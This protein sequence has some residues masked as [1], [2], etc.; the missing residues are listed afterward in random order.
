MTFLDLTLKVEAT[1]AK[2]QTAKKTRMKRQPTDLENIFANCV[3]DKKL[4]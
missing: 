1:K 3:S 2:K 4:V